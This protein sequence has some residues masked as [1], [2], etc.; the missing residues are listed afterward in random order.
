DASPGVLARVREL[1]IADDASGDLR[2][3]LAGADLVILCVPVGAIGAVA[4]ACAPYLERGAIL[5]DV[6]SVKGSVVAQVAPHV[7][8]GV[9][10]IPAHPLAGTEFSGPDA[11]FA[12]LFHNRWCILTPPNGESDGVEKLAE[13]WK[14]LGAKV[15]TTTTEH[16]DLALAIT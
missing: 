12:T 16:H 11:G 3:A 2:S 6:G 9:H 10:F 14:R 15:E 4:R 5:S 7:P 13:F 8:E 1:G